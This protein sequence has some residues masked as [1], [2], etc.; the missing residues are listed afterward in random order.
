MRSF[1][2]ELV[3]VFGSPVAE[4]PTQVMMEAAFAQ[5]GL[6]WRYLTVEVHPED[7]RDAVAGARAMNWRG[8]NCTIP[9]KVA[10]IPYLDQLTP[11][12]ELIGAVNCV[13][14]QEREWIGDNT[15]GKGFVESLTTVRPIAGI[16]AVI[17]G[18]GGAARAIAVELALAG[19]A[20]LTIVNRDH[21][22]REALLKSLR[23]RTG[24]ACNAL[25]WE[26]EFAI[27]EH[28]ELLVNATS[29]GLYPNQDALV[30]VDLSTLRPGLIVCDV[31]PNPPTTRLL[32]EAQQ[33]GA[34]TLDGL[35]MLVSQGIIGL[36]LWTGLEADPI[37]MRRA[38][39]A[40]LQ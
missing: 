11:A 9:H 12:A 22:R 31:V 24:A 20:E 34:T 36:R 35:G 30:P 38:L 29:V 33:R 27:P 17:L 15:D 19:A 26:G 16:R 6:D 39:A 23:E 25:P 8:F 21:A 37:V 1:K 2:Q 28:A 3:G 7:L 4:N 32:A 5:L 40:A 13:V 10:V 14:N 18:A